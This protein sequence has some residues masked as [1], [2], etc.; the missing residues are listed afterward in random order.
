ME[1]GNIY[2][3]GQIY[4]I[5]SH[6]TDLIY[7][8]STTQPLHKRFY[9]HNRSKK[10]VSSK[11]IMKYEDAYIELIEDFPCNSKKELNRREGH[12]IRNTENCVNKCVAGRTKKEWIVDNL[13]K[14]ASY[15]KKFYDLNKDILNKKAR[16]KYHKKR[17]SLNNEILNDN[18]ALL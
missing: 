9:E 5:R 16:E 1:K 18:Q 8:G 12:H 6:Q 3:N 15:H 14:E 10:T 4:A 7:I 13:K 2:A 11:E 17:T